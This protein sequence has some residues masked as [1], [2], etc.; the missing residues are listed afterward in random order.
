MTAP[1][2][3]SPDRRMRVG[4]LLYGVDR[5]L[6]GITRM[7]VE[8]GR[9]LQRSGRCKIT[10]LTPYRHGP[11]RGEDGTWSEW[12][13][14]C[15]LLPGLMVFGGPELAVIAR[16][17]R[18][19][20]IHDPTGVSPFTLPHWAGPRRRVVTVH[21]AIAIHDP[22]GYPWLNRFL[23]R[24]YL[25][26]T[27]GNVD[28]VITVSETSRADLAK[29]LRVPNDRL[30]VVPN[31]V[32]DEFRPVPPEEA[33][34]VAQR[35]GL[36][37]PFILH[38]GIPWERKNLKRLVDAFAHVRDSRP[39]CRLALVGSRLRPIESLVEHIDRAGLRESVAL[40]GHVPDG[41]LP[42]LYS[43]AKVLAFPSLHE[44]FGLPILEAMACGT[45]VVCSDTSSLPE[46]A[47]GAAML[48]NP[49]DVRALGHA[50][51]QVLQNP[52]VATSLRTRGLDRAATFTWDSIAA[53]TVDVYSAVAGNA[54]A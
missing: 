1:P 23:H 32:S 38:V 12:L 9:A 33:R 30:H 13:P 8:L 45:P 48:V 10:F 22:A 52:G 5:P 41:D 34:H 51:L 16:R 44:G 4:F 25:P 29:Y 17:L 14:G 24:T 3:E 35:Y 46:V 31:G 43:A 20:L 7:A 54:G 40:L 47:G 37:G 11:F 28:A 19:E 39:D 6:S 50:L 15:G 42:A 2:T 53:K 36:A 26:A 18:L 21:D 49:L 27:L